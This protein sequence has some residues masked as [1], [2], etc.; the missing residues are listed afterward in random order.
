MFLFGG[1]DRDDD[2][3][4]VQSPFIFDNEIAF[5]KPLP[6]EYYGSDFFPVDSEEVG[7]V[8]LKIKRY[9]DESG[10]EFALVYQPSQKT[11]YMARTD[12]V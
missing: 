7:R 9:R 5:V 12:L 8:D 3:E 2:H 4:C 11:L 6:C 1:S 10:A